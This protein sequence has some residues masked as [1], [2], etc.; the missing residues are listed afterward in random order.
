MHY[1][2][3]LSKIQKQD[4][5]HAKKRAPASVT[6]FAVSVLICLTLT[7]PAFC[8]D[9]G[10]AEKET[11]G[12]GSVIFVSVHD[13]SGEL[14][15]TP[16]MVKLCRGTI[17]SGRQQ[18]SRGIAE[19]VVTTLGEFTVDVSAPGYEATQK[20]LS[21]HIPGRAQVDVYLRRSPGGGST[22][23]VPGRPVL[24]PKAKEALDKGLLA[25]GVDKTADAEKYLNEAMRLA[26]G[27]P[28]VLYAQGVLALKQHN[29]AQA[30]TALEKAT[31]IDPNH[32]QAYAALGMALCDEGKCDAAIV[33]LEKS[34]QL[35]ASGTWETRWALAKAY[36]HHEQYDD[37]LKMSQ[38]A[39]AVS[40]GK[41]PEIELLLAQSQTAVG[42]YE[43]AARTLRNFL[44]NHGDRHEAPTARRWLASLATSGKISAN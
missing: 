4:Q 39:L 29:W 26:P 9:G 33:P 35:D 31:Q 24:T 36:Y 10:S 7:L 34:L 12:N 43:D 18:T 30:Q 27:H 2:Q 23:G 13:G 17:P 37:A 6:R 32:A 5:V 20:D 38:Q 16:A 3:V 11:Y 21:V 28:D 14:I 1:L 44:K 19:L 8:Q 41:A 15:S 40:N 42:S 22:S 25:L